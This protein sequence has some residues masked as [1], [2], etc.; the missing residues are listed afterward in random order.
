MRFVPILGPGCQVKKRRQVPEEQVARPPRRSMTTMSGQSGVRQIEGGMDYP[1]MS[2]RV[3][4]LLERHPAGREQ[5]SRGE[6]IWQ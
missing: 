6:E 3:T 4:G 5:E 2:I 1:V